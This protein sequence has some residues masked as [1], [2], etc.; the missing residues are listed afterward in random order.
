MGRG[1]LF[2]V[3]CHQMMWSTL[4]SVMGI[5]PGD[6]SVVIGYQVDEFTCN[7]SAK[8]FV[9]CIPT[10]ILGSLARCHH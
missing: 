6:S 1:L 8:Q 2:Q 5:K 10:F 3:W 7:W 9:A 4:N